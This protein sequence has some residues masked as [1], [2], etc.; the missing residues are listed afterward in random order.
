MND[1]I[2]ACQRQCSCLSLVILLLG[3]QTC[4]AKLI[5]CGLRQFFPGYVHPMRHYSCSMILGHPNQ[6]GQ[7]FS[8]FLKCPWCIHSCFW[9]SDYSVLATL[10]TFPG[11]V[12]SDGLEM[13]VCRYPSLPSVM[14]LCSKMLQN[15]TQ[16]R[17]RTRIVLVHQ[18]L[19]ESC[20]MTNQE[21][22]SIQFSG[23]VCRAARR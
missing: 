21:I 2:T 9:R 13:P 11:L 22:L 4:L 3:C 5:S 12:D 1:H 8:V 19:R 10:T 16:R 18:F 6:G 17:C 20:S 7:K 14:V 15:A 23:N